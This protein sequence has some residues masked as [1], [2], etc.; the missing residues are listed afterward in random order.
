M[1]PDVRQVTQNKQP[2]ARRFLKALF[3][4]PF[5]K[6]GALLLAVFFWALVIAS[7]PSLLI[8]KTLAGAV[9]SVSGMETLRNRG[10]TVTTDLTSSPITVKMKVQ[11]KQGNYELVTNESFV[12]RLDLAQQVSTVGTQQ[13]KF[14]VPTTTLGKVLSFEPDSIEINVEP[15][16]PRKIIPVVID[17]VGESA[18]PL[19]VGQP[20]VDPQQVVLSGPKS[21]VD[22]VRRAAVRLDRGSLSTARPTDSMAVLLELQDEAGNPIV[23]PLLNITSDSVVINSVTVSVDVYPMREIPVSV[24]TAAIGIPA[25]GYALQAVHITPDTVFVAASPQTLD[26]IDTLHIASPVDVSDS[27]VS[28][29]ESSGL[30]GLSDLRYLSTTEVLVEAEVAPAIHTHTYTAIPVAVMGASSDM[31][32]K[33]SHGTMRCV[34]SGDYTAVEGLSAEDIYLYVDATGLPEG[35]YA[36]PVLTRVDGTE[37]YDVSLE[38]PE[39]SLTLSR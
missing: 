14:T 39:V 24:D 22:S 21:L 18:E 9:V 25:H 11:V 26:A 29:I 20:R 10:L 38:W 4:R 33:V 34:I 31:V 13:V 1:Q 16:T 6:L 23:S 35:T 17:Q 27:S 19:W 36:V 30:R 7:D 12:P 3:Q 5:L 15:Y 32:A 2:N 37:A 28:V 8:E